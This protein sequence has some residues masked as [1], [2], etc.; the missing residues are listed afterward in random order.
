MTLQRFELHLCDV[1]PGFRCF[2]AG[3]KSKTLALVARVQHKIGRAASSKSLAHIKKALGKAASGLQSF[4]EAHDGVLLYKDSRSDAAGVEF[5]KSAEWDSRTAE[6]RES[7][8]A[9][10]FEPSEMPEWFEQ[11]LV[12][13]EIPH[14]A[15]YFV[16]QLRGK[17]SGRIF[18]ADHD[19]FEPEPIA[20][21]FDEFVQL[22]VDDPPGFLYAR[23]CYTR[24][25]DGKTGKQW[26]PKE[27]I[28]DAR[29]A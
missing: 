9:M 28:P 2:A 13:G 16:I 21:S 7:M 19:A 22:I 15:N 18:Y 29:N 25:S 12:F 23:G 11:G 10:G 17:D 6:M 20:E 26:I 1:A 3:D 8:Q 4:C 24:Y 5:F 27:Y 14:S